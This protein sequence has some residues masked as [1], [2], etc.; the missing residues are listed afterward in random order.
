MKPRANSKPFACQAV[1]GERVSRV[2]QL[3]PD[4]RKVSNSPVVSSLDSVLATT[5]RRTSPYRSLYTC[6]YP[7]PEDRTSGLGSANQ[8][9]SVTDDKFGHRCFRNLSYFRL[10]VYVLTSALALPRVPRV[11]STTSPITA[12]NARGPRTTR[13]RGWGRPRAAGHQGLVQR[14]STTHKHLIFRRRTSTP[15]LTAGLASWPCCSSSV[16]SYRIYL[17]SFLGL[18]LEYRSRGF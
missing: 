10:L 6:I 13:C 2:H 5:G 9:G 14:A 3:L 12:H 7:I 8:L 15:R 17:V 11:P 1:A 18:F 16:S 4:M